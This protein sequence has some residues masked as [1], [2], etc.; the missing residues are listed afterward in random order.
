MDASTIGMIAFAAVLILLA[1]RV[2]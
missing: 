2:P 1:L